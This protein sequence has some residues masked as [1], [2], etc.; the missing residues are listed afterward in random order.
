MNIFSNN[1]GDITVTNSPINVNP[2]Q[3]A[4]KPWEQ[5]SLE[6]LRIGKIKHEKLLQEERDKR[7]KVAVPLFV[8]FVIFI[9][10]FMLG[11]KF[12]E[13][14]NPLLLSFTAIGTLISLIVFL[15]MTD[16]KTEFWIRQEES[17]K[18]IN[19]QI[20]ESGNQNDTRS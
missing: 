14:I 4:F 7:K 12:E 16:T 9:G 18:E 11:Q 1:T 20:R 15:K 17:L 8:T 10:L 3:T 2:P 19:F 5:C 6:E 13:W